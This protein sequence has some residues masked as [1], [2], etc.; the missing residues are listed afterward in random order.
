MGGSINI[1]LLIIEDNEIERAAIKAFFEDN[2]YEVFEAENGVLGIDVF[3]KQKPDIVITDLYMP[4]MNGHEVI[5]V[6]RKEA[7]AT[8]IIVVSGMGDLT[9]AVNAVR[10]GAWDYVTKPIYDMVVLEHRINNALE[11]A[12][13]LEDNKRYQNH[14]EYLVQERTDDL[15]FTNK[16]LEKEIELCIRYENRLSESERKFRTLVHNVNEYIYS[17][18]FEDNLVIS[19][20]HSPK[21][22]VI[23]GYTPEEYLADKNLWF[24]MIHPEDQPKVTSFLSEIEQTCMSSTIEHRIFHK[25]GTIHW[26]SNTCNSRTDESGRLIALDGFIIDITE[27]KQVEQFRDDVER[28]FRHDI[29][30]PLSAIIACVSLLD[31]TKLTEDQKQWIS[32]IRESGDR[33]INML[34]HS[35][36]HFKMEEGSYILNPARFDLIQLFRELHNEFIHFHITKSVALILWLKDKLIADGDVYII[37][38]ERVHVKTLFANLIKNALEASP[39]KNKVTI[40]IQKVPKFHHIQIHNHGVIPKSIREKF[41]DRYTTS[42]KE[43]GTGLGTYSAM[44]IAKA[45]EGSITFTTSKKEGTS[46]KVILPEL[47]RNG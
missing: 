30:N 13:L 11:R 26:V 8:P 47:L 1:K 38:G 40:S 27:R 42:G 33:L 45:H 28:V 9:D 2:D 5:S 34:K 25:D 17:V 3:K 32:F 18:D 14:L 7:S 10:L 39:E 31:K 15:N 44:L 37:S 24:D 12:K 21:C 35:L 19:T 41:F 6:I 4:E 22:A 20:Y 23:T 46:V 43:N 16:L 36:E 29:K